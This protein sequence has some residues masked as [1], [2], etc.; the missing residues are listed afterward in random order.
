MLGK[1][2]KLSWFMIYLYLVQFQYERKIEE[3]SEQADMIIE[4]PLNTDKAI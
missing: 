4:Y 1:S 3:V 2:D